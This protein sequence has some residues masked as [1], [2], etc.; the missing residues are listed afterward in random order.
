MFNLISDF[1]G[2]KPLEYLWLVI[3]VGVTAVASYGGTW[4]DGICAIT[5]VMSV[6]LVAKGR[7]SN[8]WWGL[9]GVITYGIVSY[10][11]HLFGNAALNIF[12]YLPMQFIGMW[13]WLRNKKS[14]RPD[15]DV[16]LVT[17]MGWVF[18]TIVTAVATYVGTVFLRLSV[19]PFPLLDSFTTVGSVL[20]MWLMV[21]RNPEQWLVWFVIDVITTYL[22]WATTAAGQH[23]YAMVAMWAVFLLNAVYGSYKWFIVKDYK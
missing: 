22:W 1:K 12:Y 10:N 18:Y 23:S 6:I 16:K 8:Y 20:A 4:L 9:V 13:M 19:D 5:N 11:N 21:R 15:V 7:M 17:P 3:A 2:W 14:D